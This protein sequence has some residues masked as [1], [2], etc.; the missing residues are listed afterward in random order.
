MRIFSDIPV[1]FFLTI[2]VIYNLCEHAVGGPSDTEDKLKAE[3][4]AGYS[5]GTGAGVGYGYGQGTGAG[6]K[7]LRTADDTG[8]GKKFKLFDGSRVFHFKILENG[9]FISIENS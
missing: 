5:Q 3:G 2:V 9:S 7:D 1:I 8:S 6:A 4:G